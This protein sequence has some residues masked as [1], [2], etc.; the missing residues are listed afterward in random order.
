VPLGGDH[1]ERAAV[2][3]AGGLGAV[4]EL[5]QPGDRLL[6]LLGVAVVDP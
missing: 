5:P 2:K 1:D 6:G 3:L 4:D